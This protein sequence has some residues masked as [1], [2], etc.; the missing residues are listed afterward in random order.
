MKYVA[1]PVEV[2]AFK[3]VKI[4]DQENTAHGV[5]QTLKSEDGFE[6]KA[7]V[8]MTARYVAQVGDYWVI[9]EDGY[10]Y[11]NPAAVFERKYRRMEPPR[12]PPEEGKAEKMRAA[13]LRTQPKPGE[14]GYGG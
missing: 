3:I 8:G 9:Q 10:V 11:L 2:D 1:N 14:P 6:L 12:T 4:L 5:T 13:G 7:T